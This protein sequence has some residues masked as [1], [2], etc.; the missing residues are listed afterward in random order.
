[1]VYCQESCTSI[2]NRYV[3]TM[4]PLRN[5]SRIL[6]CVSRSSLWW[7]SYLE[8]STV[9]LCPSAA[10]HARFSWVSDVTININVICFTALLTHLNSYLCSKDIASEKPMMQVGQYV[11]AGEYEGKKKKKK[12]VSSSLGLLTIRKID[13]QRHLL[14][15]TLLFCS[16][17]MA[18]DTPSPRKYCLSVPNT[19]LDIN[20]HFIDYFFLSC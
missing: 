17:N 6:I 4:Y 11:F 18:I 20:L 3:Q 13:A 10:V 16:K 5:R 9:T 19:H 2:V 14:Y 12:A 15:S 8:L 7:W 1:M